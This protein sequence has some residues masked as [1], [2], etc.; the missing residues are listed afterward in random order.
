MKK[1]FLLVGPSGSGKT[2]LGEYFK[3]CNIPELV[4]HTTR[5]IRKNEIPGVTYHYIDKSNFDSIDKIEY[6][7]Y[8][9]NFYCL[10][11]QEVNNKLEKHDKVF[12]VTDLNGVRQIKD[13]YPKETISIF[14]EV[15]LDEMVERMEKRGDSKKAIA[16]RVYNAI[17][18]N[19]LGNGDKCDYIIRN[20]DFSNSKRLL[21]SIIKLE[22]IKNINTKEQQ[23]VM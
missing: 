4:S 12:A 17:M 6:T 3:Q 20:E 11:T 7:E 13:R 21:S 8:A 19:E 23:K 5:N 22:S 2:S 14:I 9:G 10:S 16:E 1:I 18:E 15:T